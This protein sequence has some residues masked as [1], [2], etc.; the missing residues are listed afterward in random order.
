MIVLAF[1]SN[2]GCR[3]ANIAGG[4]GLL[5]SKYAV[6]PV[7]LSSLYETEPVGVTAQPAFLNAVIS[8]RTEL[9]PLDLLE[10]CLATEGTL[11]RTRTERWGPRTMDIDVIFYHE[12][13]LDGPRL[14]LPHPHF[15]E[16]R[17]VL[18]PLFEITGNLPLL[19]G[20]TAADMLAATSDRSSVTRVCGLK[21]EK[22]AV[23]FV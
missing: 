13:I 10:A 2:L 21:W 15:R 19:K 16:R 5:A 14:T 20:E 3:E 23:T 22:E 18:V 9:A 1:G 7:S 11:G 4:I 12:L 6:T 8:V 17:F